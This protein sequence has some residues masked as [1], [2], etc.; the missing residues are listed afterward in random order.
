MHKEKRRFIEHCVFH[1]EKHNVTHCEK[2]DSQDILFGAREN[3]FYRAVLS[4]NWREIR[5]VKQEFGGNFKVEA[6]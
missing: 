6:I 5:S 3:A 4:R 1:N 2:I